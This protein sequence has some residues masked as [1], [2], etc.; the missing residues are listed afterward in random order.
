MLMN[1]ILLFRI[2]GGP[3]QAIRHCDEAGNETGEIHE[4]D[5][6]DDA[7]AFID[8]VDHPFARLIDSGQ[9]DCQIVSLDEL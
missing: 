6:M 4:F 5:H 9:V 8:A 2:N 3:V 1:C 7:L